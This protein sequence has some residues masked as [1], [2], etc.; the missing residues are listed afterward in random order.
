MRVLVALAA[1]SMTA[2][3][4]GGMR[5]RLI[6][7][8]DGLRA[9][10]APIVYST[11]LAPADL[12][13]EVD[14]I[15]LEAVRGA[16]PTV[17]LKLDERDGNWL[18]VRGPT[19]ASQAQHS[20]A[21]GEEQSRDASRIETIIVTGTR[22]RF[23]AI[24]PEPANVLSSEELDRLPALGGDSLRSA[25]L[26]PGMS[27]MGVSVSPKIRGGLEDEVLVLLDGVEII[28]PYHFANYQNLFSAI[29]PRVIDDVDVYSGGFPARYGNR[30]SG[31]MEIDS[32]E[33]RDK[34]TAEV[35][36]S[37][38]SAFAN[39]RN[40][41]PDSDTTWLASARYGASDL[42][43]QRLGLQSGQPYFSDALFRVGHSFDPDAKLYFGG[44]VVDEDVSLNDAGQRAKW[45]TNGTYL[46][47]RFDARLDDRF[48]SSTV[49]SYVSSRNQ[50]R[51]SSAPSQ[52][53]AAGTLYDSR[54]TERVRTAQRFCHC[55]R[56]SPSGV[57]RAGGLDPNQLRFQSA[58]RSRPRLAY[59]STARP[60]LRTTSTPRSMVWPAD[61]TGRA[62]SRSA[63][64]CR[65]SP[66]YAGTIRRRKATRRRFHPDSG[67][68]G[69]RP[70]I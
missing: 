8:L 35:G 33:Q 25:N 15:T 61:S 63:P 6:D 31:V 14:A 42:L 53:V 56:A 38:Y 54:D 17:G 50:I 40:A 36:L 21:V 9:Q 10:G 28:D 58:D 59:C 22:H 44:L 4:W 45:K 46:W 32:L 5:V 48:T 65:F 20:D 57:R 27:S 2:I 19:I 70:T 26:L 51:D 52:E 60:Y 18:L 11:A 16:L 29:D 12:Y 49:V 43:I 34:P 55:D 13:I 69:Y 66:A 62:I 41:N 68:N 39:A 67:S 7:A 64:T 3:A 47:S 37:M 24:G 30:M 1:L 23:A